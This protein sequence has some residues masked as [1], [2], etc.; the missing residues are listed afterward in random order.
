MPHEPAHFEHRQAC[1]NRQARVGMPQPV[2]AEAG[3]D[4]GTSGAVGPL[5][6]RPEHRLVHPQAGD[7]PGCVRALAALAR[8]HRCCRCL[9][10]ARP[11]TRQ[12]GL[13]GRLQWHIA[14]ELAGSRAL[15]MLG[16]D[17]CLHVAGGFYGR[18]HQ[19]DQQ[20]SLCRQGLPISL[21]QFC[22]NGPLSLT[23]TWYKK[24]ARP[25]H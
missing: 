11:P 12:A 4:P 2:P 6:G 13:L 24:E 19:N 22:G 10:A 20:S 15:L 7:G 17:C 23:I 25:W 21:S 18:P 3:R 5:P 16:D 8:H 1:R 14:G 9:G